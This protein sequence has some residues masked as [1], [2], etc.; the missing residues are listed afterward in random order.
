M[1]YLYEE[2]SAPTRLY[3]KQC[4]HCGLKYFGKTTSED[5]EKYEGSGV[6]WQRHLKKHGATPIHLWNSDWYYDTSIIR[7]AIK[8]SNL[9]KI[10]ESKEWANLAIENGMQGGYLGEE[11]SKRISEG[12]KRVQSTDEWKETVGKEATRRRQKTRRKTVSDPKWKETV[13]KEATKKRL[14]TVSDPEWKETVGKKSREKISKTRNDP[15]WK[16]NVGKKAKEKE[17]LTKSDP[18]WKETVGNLAAK[19]CG[20]TQTSDKWKAENHKVCPYCLKGP[21]APGMYTR[22]HGKNCKEYKNV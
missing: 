14:E 8:F 16:E 7:F 15:D 2:L 4:P 6:R 9:N 1:T 18:N 10:V 11:V 17:L 13:G 5:I 3:I 20:E 19:R 21:F 22:W 12:V